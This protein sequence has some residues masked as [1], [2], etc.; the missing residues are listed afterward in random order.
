MRIYFVR[1]QGFGQVLGCAC[2]VFDV[3]GIKLESLRMADA[4]KVR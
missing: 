1:R 3:L 2:F 4:K